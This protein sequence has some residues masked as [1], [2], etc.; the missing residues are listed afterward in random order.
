MDRSRRVGELS[1]PPEQKSE[2]E[3][4]RNS[5][6]G[7][8]KKRNSAIRSSFSFSQLGK[9][10]RVTMRDFRDAVLEL[11]ACGSSFLRMRCEGSK[12]LGQTAFSKPP[13]SRFLHT[14]YVLRWL[15]L[16]RDPMMQIHMF[17]SVYTS[18]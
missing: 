14:R 11:Y 12:T 17:I 15:A 3:K 18:W 8:E 6:G 4:E 2:R 10:D 13:F 7:T 9:L 1:K 16:D 5:E